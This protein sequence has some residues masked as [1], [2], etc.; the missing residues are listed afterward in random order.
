MVY[1]PWTP[2]GPPYQV[3]ARFD[4]SPDAVVVAANAALRE[5]LPRTM[6]DARTARWYIDA[7]LEELGPGEALIFALGLAAVVLAVIG[8]FGVV[9]LSVTRRRAELGI[10]LALGARAS[11]IYRAVVGSGLGPVLSGL[12][13]GIV[14]ALGTA[15]AF[16]SVFASMH[17]AVSARDPSTY[18]LVAL[19]LA[20]VIGAALAVPARRAARLDP[21]QTIRFE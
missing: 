21:L 1:A 20:L 12:V 9:S 4:G 16:A 7:W 17:L 10:R 5:A 2:A 18:T 8:V 11:H 14:L 15:T 13:V 19:L 6:V 3:V